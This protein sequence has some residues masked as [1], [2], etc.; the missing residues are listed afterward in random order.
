MKG[1][2]FFFFLFPSLVLFLLP[3]L[4]FSFFSRVSRVSLLL[5]LSSFSLSPPFCSFFCFCL[6]CVTRVHW[7]RRTLSLFVS[8]PTRILK[9]FVYPC[10]LLRFLAGPQWMSG[11]FDFPLRVSLYPPSCLAPLENP[12]PPQRTHYIN[13]CF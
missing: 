2:V 6:R 1:G 13:R 8:S 3:A 10:P 12:F 5:P 7:R 9:S 4:F 11:T